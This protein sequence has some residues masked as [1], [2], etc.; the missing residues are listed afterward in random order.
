MSD[1][2]H[3]SGLEVLRREHL[4]HVR[5]FRLWR[6]RRSATLELVMDDET[7]VSYDLSVAQYP[8]FLYRKALAAVV[9]V[10]ALWSGQKFEFHEEGFFF[11]WRRI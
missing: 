9:A 6:D 2:K 7:A 5:E 10:H 11:I 4:E 1:Q 8:G 3:L